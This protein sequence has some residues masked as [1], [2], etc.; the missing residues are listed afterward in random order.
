MY[1]AYTVCVKFTTPHA[2]YPTATRMPTTLP[3]LACTGSLLPCRYPHA[4][5]TL[6]AAVEAHLL[7]LHLAPL[8]RRMWRAQSIGLCFSGLCFEGLPITPC[9]PILILTFRLAPPCTSSRVA[10]PPAKSPRM[11][12]PSTVSGPSPPAPPPERHGLVGDAHA[13]C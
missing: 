11:P 8:A 4:G 13:F 9:H 3:L 6:D 5:H 1:V 10:A 2:Y 7:V 12:L